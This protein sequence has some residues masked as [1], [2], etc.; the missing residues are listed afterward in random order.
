MYEN[1]PGY[2]I[3]GV[4]VTGESYFENL[5][6]LHANDINPLHSKQGAMTV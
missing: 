2:A 4:S 3:I 1:S 5:N 6:V